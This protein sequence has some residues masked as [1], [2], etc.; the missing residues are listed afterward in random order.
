M[1][2][3]ARQDFEDMMLLLKVQLQELKAGLASYALVEEMMQA[4][5][6]GMITQKQ[7]CTSLQNI[8]REHPNAW[9]ASSALLSRLHLYMDVVRASTLAL[10]TAF[11]RNVYVYAAVELS[12]ISSPKG[13]V[14]TICTG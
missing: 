3:D 2:E 8:L 10:C 13:H 4:C 7:L 14:L 5:A 9:Q 12:W 1:A 11:G 6:Q